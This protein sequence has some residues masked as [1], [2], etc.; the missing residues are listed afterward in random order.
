MDLQQQEMQHH[1]FWCLQEFYHK[2]VPPIHDQLQSLS[3][4]KIFP[5]PIESKIEANQ[6][7]SE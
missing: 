3:V 2:I 6:S 7:I 1:P 4:H 5:V